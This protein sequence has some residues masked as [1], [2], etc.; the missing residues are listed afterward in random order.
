MA[1][2]VAGS[3]KVLKMAPFAV[4]PECDAVLQCAFVV[5]YIFY[6]CIA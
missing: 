3:F 2:S 5:G 4:Q 6:T 1:G